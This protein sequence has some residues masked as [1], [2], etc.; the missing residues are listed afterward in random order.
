[1][2][3]LVAGTT[4]MLGNAIFNVLTRDGYDVHGLS[5]AEFVSHNN[6]S[7]IN[8]DNFEAFFG[9]V[10][11]VQ[12][13][14]IVNCIGIIK[15][16]DEVSNL[17]KLFDVNSKFPILLAYAARRFNIKL[18]HFSTDC[19]FSGDRG[20]YKEWDL[21]DPIDAYGLSK[22]A[23]ESCIGDELV[24]RTSII[25]RGVTPNSS[26]ID[27]FLSRRG[28]VS[29]YNKA[30]FS[31]LPVNE[32]AKVLS[33]F[34]PNLVGIS[35]LYHLS[36]APIDKFSLLNLVKDAW[37][38]DIDIIPDDSL[39]INRSLDSKLLCQAIEYSPPHWSKLVSEMCSYYS[40]NI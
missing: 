17:R 13:D 28:Q 8:I 7:G 2:R 35:G 23:G 22:L 30:I 26:L 4:G 5:R 31:G 32:I 21:P 16:V 9:R 25:G 1:M 15:Q 24:L 6:T 14:V 3:V 12:P 39:V 27:W 20:G 18:I 34:L 37:N 29:G 33:R 40:Q 10:R 11:S 36:A 19:V 38:V